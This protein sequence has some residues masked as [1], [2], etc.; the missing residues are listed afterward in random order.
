MIE[1]LIAQWKVEM[2]NT[3]YDRSK[4]INEICLWLQFCDSKERKKLSIIIF[5][6]FI[7]SD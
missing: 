5:V 1:I 2:Q 3:N 7:L 4:I 6:L